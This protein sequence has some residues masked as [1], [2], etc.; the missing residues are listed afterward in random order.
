MLGIEDLSPSPGTDATAS[1][2]CRSHGRPQD[3][4]Q[5]RANA[6]PRPEGPRQGGV[7][8]EGLRPPPR[9]LMG[10]A[11]TTFAPDFLCMVKSGDN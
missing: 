9:Q 6:E 7:L 1:E 11:A 5:G 2:N 8:G 3:V 10:L 4:F